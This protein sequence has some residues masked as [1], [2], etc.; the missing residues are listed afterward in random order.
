MTTLVLNTAATWGMVG[1]IWTIQVV[2]YPMLVTLSELRPA[3]AAADHQRRITWVVGP[4]MALEGVTTLV[5]LASRPETMNVYSAWAG[6]ILLAVALGS[7][8]VAQVP[9]HGRLAAG[10]D[11]DAAD[12]LVTTNWVRTA[13]WTARGILLTGVLV[14]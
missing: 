9:L 13:A 5:L 4:L 10:H 6:A 14:T 7:T 11:A 2:H 3:T 1:V 8:V 12:R